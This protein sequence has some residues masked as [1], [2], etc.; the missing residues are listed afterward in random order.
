MHPLP[1]DRSSL[2]QR[3]TFRVAEFVARNPGCNTSAIQTGAENISATARQA[4]TRYLNVAR[5]NGWLT[6]TGLTKGARYFPTQEFLHHTSIARIYEPVEARPKVGYDP[7]FLAAYEPNKTFMLSEAQRKSLADA[8]PPGSYNLRDEKFTQDLRRF[9]TDIA[10]N[11][12]SFEGVNVRYADTI[13]FLEE[14]IASQDMSPKEAAILR[15]HY[16]AIRFIINNTHFPPDPRDIDLSEYDVR[17][18]HAF[19]S[20]GLLKDRRL[21]GRLRYE[22]KTIHGS[23]YIPPDNP[24]YIQNIFAQIMR[25]A[26]Q[27]D[28]PFEK[29]FFVSVHLPYLQPFDDCNKRTARVVCNIPLLTAG[30][31][32]ISWSEVNQRDYADSLICVYECTSTYGMAQ[33]FE[34][35]CRRSFERFE[36]SQKNREPARIEITYA[37]QIAE[38]VR[39]RVLYGGG[40]TFHRGIEPVHFAQFES[41]VNEI[42]EAIKENE[43]VA[44]PYG[45]PRE[46]VERWRNEAMHR[47]IP[48]P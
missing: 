20:D 19:L 48:V 43:M 45:L 11:S 13:S 35:T 33:V 37:K 40:E 9:M 4:F 2:M 7:E 16:N 44:G 5:E 8:C 24:D 18:I 3:E 42:L 41:I 23:S 22:P 36:V 27:I 17:N 46:A 30:V 25:T 38:A 32:P 1:T 28:D 12:A 21:Q 29:A 14:N 26:R 10:H 15:N 47:D 39:N 6:R 31:L 34:Q